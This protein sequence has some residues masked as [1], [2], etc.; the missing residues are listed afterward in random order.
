MNTEENLPVR[1][2]KKSV[3]YTAFCPLVLMFLALLVH[4][5]FEVRGLLEQRQQIR[6]VLNQV[7]NQVQ[8]AKALNDTL[9]HLSQ[10]LVLLSAHSAESKK[11]VQEFQIE[12]RERQVEA[13]KGNK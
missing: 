6:M 9:A 2:K 8:Q 13:A 1:L 3:T 12:L 5:G 11:I 10:E 4:F 7:T